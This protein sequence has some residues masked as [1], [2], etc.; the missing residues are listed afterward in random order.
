[1]YET[2]RRASKRR[3]EPQ[4]FGSQLPDVTPLF[5]NVT[6]P[7]ILWYW[8]LKSLTKIK[9]FFW[10]LIRFQ[11]QNNCKVS[12]KISPPVYRFLRVSITRKLRLDI[13]NKLL[14]ILNLSKLL[15]KVNWNWFLKNISL[16]SRHLIYNLWI[17]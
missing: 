8:E 3:V 5:E 10:L 1:M 9:T 15:M 14:S 2:N 13:W 17:T 6:W 7:D 16:N 12:V 11:W 4:Y